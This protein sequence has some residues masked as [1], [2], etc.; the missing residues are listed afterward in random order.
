MHSPASERNKG[1]I[2]DELRRRLPATGKVLELACGSM[3]HALHFCPHFPQLTWQPT[4]I[5]PVALEHGQQLSNRPTNVLA[6]LHLDATELPWP[7]SQVDAIYTANLLHISPAKVVTALFAGACQAL[8]ET[9][10]VIIYGPFKLN[11]EHT[12]EGNHNFDLDLRARNP[13]WGIRDL[14]EVK[15]AAS[16]RGFQLIERLRMP[17]NNQL[18]HFGHTERS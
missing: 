17:A 7:I 14:A 10:T 1:P 8:H 9:G 5:N 15:E 6:P 4:D 11:G 16:E 13:E 12:S 2:L 18:L 3:Q